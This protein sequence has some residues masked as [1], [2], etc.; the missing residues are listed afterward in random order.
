[1]NKDDSGFRWG[2]FEIHGPK[3]WPLQIQQT[4]GSVY[5]PYDYHPRRAKQSHG[6]TDADLSQPIIMK[7]NYF[8]NFTHARDLG[9]A[10]F[11]YWDNCLLPQLMYHNAANPHG[12]KDWTRLVYRSTA[13]AGITATEGELEQHLNRVN[14]QIK[15]ISQGSKS[16]LW[17]ILPVKP[18][19]VR[20]TKILVCLSAQLT[21]SR[22]YNEN[23]ADL[24]RR[25]ES[26]AQ[27]RGYTVEYQRE[28]APQS[29]RW[30]RQSHASVIE[31]RL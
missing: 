24:R 15:R 25:I 10:E 26:W 30:H 27:P 5:Y 29:T 9:D 22:W 3:P 31:H 8:E 28:T 17:D 14:S 16:S 19:T 7:G 11:Y 23:L 4:G 12:D 1:M 21:I 18:V 13:P 20:G 6:P 2:P